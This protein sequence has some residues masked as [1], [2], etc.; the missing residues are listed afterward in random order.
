MTALFILIPVGLAMCSLLWFA[1]SLLIWNLRVE[2]FTLT[3][4]VMLAFF[5]PVSLPIVGFAYMC[6]GMRHLVKSHLGLREKD[7]G[8]K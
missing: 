5:W 8:G 1:T 6:K 3:D 7:L 4:C 2:I